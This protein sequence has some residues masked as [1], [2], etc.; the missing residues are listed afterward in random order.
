[1]TTVACSHG[2]LQVFSIPRV[3]KSV[4][5]DR[6]DEDAEQYSFTL[7]DK[8]DDDDDDRVRKINELQRR[9]SGF[10]CLTFKA[11]QQQRQQT[12]NNDDSN[13]NSVRTINELPRNVFSKIPRVGRSR[14]SS[15]EHE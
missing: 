7:D 1:M 6:V 15:Y 11:T 10:C 4:D 2:S 13:D 9:V 3:G 12:S 14:W 8:H 5:M